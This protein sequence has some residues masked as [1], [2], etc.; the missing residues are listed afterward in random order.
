MVTY[1]RTFV[2]RYACMFDY[3]IH[4]APGDNPTHMR[5]ARKLLSSSWKLQLPRR[6]PSLAFKLNPTPSFKTQKPPAP[7]TFKF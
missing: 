3:N 4:T 5:T 1:A 2:G 6:R 7:E